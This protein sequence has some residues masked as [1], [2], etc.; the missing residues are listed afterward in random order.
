LRFYFYN[1]IAQIIFIY[2]P[3]AFNFDP[4]S[5]SSLGCK[6]YYFL[7]YGLDAISAWCL[8]YISFEKFVAITYP[9]KRF[10]FKRK[11]TQINFFLL[12]I[13]FNFFYNLSIP[14]YVDI[15]KS[16]FNNTSSSNNCYFIDNE[17][18][19]IFSYMDLVNCV[20]VPFFLM[21]LFSCL[22]ILS[23]FKIRR[24]V[25]LNNANREHKRLKKDI[26][27]AVSLLSMNLLFILLNLPIEIYN[28]IYTNT[29]YNNN[30]YISLSYIYNLSSAVNFYLNLLTNNLFRKE[31]LL[32]LFKKKQDQTRVIQMQTL[33]IT[34]NNNTN[35]LLTSTTTNGKTTETNLLI[36]TTL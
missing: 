13:G 27:F 2:I 11:T 32:L 14:F 3:N 16:N 35:K 21:I 7:N 15:L 6:I 19:I 31:T 25:H 1:N 28:L 12:L 30:I 29:Y 34:N 22:L 17:K 8:V 20:L 24:N 33:L 10:I 36:T 26:K 4:T 23:I 18:E 5:I 9:S